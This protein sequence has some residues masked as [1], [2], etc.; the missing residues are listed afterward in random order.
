MLKDQHARRRAPT[1]LVARVQPQ[2]VHDALTSVAA[3]GLIDVFAPRDDGRCDV[4]GQRIDR[5]DRKLRAW[6][7]AMGGEYEKSSEDGGIKFAGPASLFVHMRRQ[8]SSYDDVRVLANATSGVD[9]LPAPPGSARRRRHITEHAKFGEDNALR[10]VPRK[11]R[12]WG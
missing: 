8:V 2:H 5:V 1:H 10:K 3:V 12:G 11:Q 6:V 9:T 7:G 4:L